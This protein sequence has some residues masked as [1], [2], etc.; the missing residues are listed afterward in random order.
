MSAL[1]AFG[2]VPRLKRLRDFGSSIK[3][4]KVGCDSRFPRRAKAGECRAQIDSLHSSGTAV[5]TQSLF[6]RR[7][8]VPIPC[9][10]LFSTQTARLPPPSRSP[11]KPLKGCSP[12]LG[13]SASPRLP[14]ALPPQATGTEGVRA[15]PQAR[16]RACAW[17]TGSPTLPSSAAPVGGTRVGWGAQLG[18]GQCFQRGREAGHRNIPQS[19]K[20]PFRGYGVCARMA[21][22]AGGGRVGWTESQ[23]DPGDSAERGKEGG[24]GR[25]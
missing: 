24:R 9:P 3:K 7:C 21:Q 8:R 18:Q 22:G 23:P 1:C 15:R 12:R 20:F 16:F 17:G 13:L 6:R 2:A 4:E 11:L 5:R 10:T 19:R 14:H 25:R